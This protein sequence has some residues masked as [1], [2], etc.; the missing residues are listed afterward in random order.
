MTETS[1]RKRGNFW[2]RPT[3]HC[4][5]RGKRIPYLA[6]THFRSPSAL[7][8]DNGLERGHLAGEACEV[9]RLDDGGAILVGAGRFLCNAP[10]RGAFDDNAALSQFVDD[11]P[12]VPA[13]Q[14][15]MPAQSSPGTMAGRSEGMLRA[16]RSPDHD[17]RRGPHAAADENR[18]AGRGEIRLKT[19]MTRTKRP[20]RALAVHKE[21]AG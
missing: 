10:H 14:G 9:R 7:D 13:L 15:L 19:G 5:R 20:S 3:A 11:L 18:L 16:L 8:A 2:H 21:P 17:R 4:Q 1:A 12:A 6:V